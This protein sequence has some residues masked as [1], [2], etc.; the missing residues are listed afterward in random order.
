MDHR[1]KRNDDVLTG[2]LCAAGSTVLYGMSFIFTKRALGSAG[3]LS[4]LGWRFLVAFITMSVPASL[5][6]VR[7]RLRGKRLGPLILLA[8]FFPV[9]YYIAEAFGV[10]MTTASESGVFMATIPVISLAASTLILRKK[11]TRLQA[12]GVLVTLAG[13]LVTVF[14]AGISSSFSVPGYLLLTAAVVSYALY[15]VLVERTSGYTGAEITYFMLITG[16]A[17]YVSLAVAEALTEGSFGRLAS[18]PFTDRGFLAAILYEGLGCSVGAFFLTNVAIAKIGVNR[19]SSFAGASPVVSILSGILFLHE[20]F[21]A[22]QAAGAAVIIA[23]VYLA[24]ARTPG[25]PSAPS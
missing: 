22:L 9:I 24:N 18:L 15:A 1:K 5:G 11:P 7:T 17:V 19:T 16:A 4:L 23:G 3:V 13:V 21:T 6:I 14:A 2:C 20:R 25:D 8:L 12:A 10:D